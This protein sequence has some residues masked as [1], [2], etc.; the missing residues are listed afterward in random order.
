MATNR[1]GKKLR[2][3]LEILLHGVDRDSCFVQ[4]SAVYCASVTVINVK[5]CHLKTHCKGAIHSSK[6]VQLP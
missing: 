1:V 3:N 4:L 2:L 5:T 6:T